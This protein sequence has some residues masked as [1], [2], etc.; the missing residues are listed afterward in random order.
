MLIVYNIIFNV[1]TFVALV[2]N[3]V[4][5][6]Y[7]HFL[8]NVYNIVFD[9]IHILGKIVFNIENDVIQIFCHLSILITKLATTVWKLPLIALL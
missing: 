4:F 8:S 6:V 7:A 9:A 2:Y 5:D 3:I 1:Y